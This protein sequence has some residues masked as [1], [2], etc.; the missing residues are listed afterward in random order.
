MQKLCNF[1]GN[2][3]KFVEIS[4]EFTTGVYM[5]IQENF[6]TWKKTAFPLINYG[7]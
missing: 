7:K 1:I 5:K 6:S 2:F 4:I 3:V